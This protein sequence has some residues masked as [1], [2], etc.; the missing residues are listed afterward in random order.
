MN[1][2]AH[3]NNAL[4]RQIANR[5][6]SFYLESIYDSERRTTVPQSFRTNAMSDF[7]ISSIVDD[8]QFDFDDEVTNAMSYRRALANL[9]S[10]GRL[11][12]VSEDYSLSVAGEEEATF[13]SPD[14]SMER[15]PC[16]HF[17]G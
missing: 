12:E 13:P 2:I 10:Q 9:R 8:R 4:L 17:A 11:R 3:K 5:G 16:A 6:R 14:H 1:D 7:E 15:E